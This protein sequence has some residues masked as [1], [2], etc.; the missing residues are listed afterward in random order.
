LRRRITAVRVVGATLVLLLALVVCGNSW[1]TPVT[2]IKP[3]V[4]FSPGEM[5]SRYLSA[6]T[7]SPYLGFPNFN[8]GLGPV[9]AALAP[10]EVLG[11]SPEWLFKV[12][13]LALW[14]VAALGARSALQ[15]LAPS[16]GSW[17]G[18]T[19]AALYVAN[20]YAVVGGSTLAILLPY[21]FLPWLVV[22]LVHALRD[23]RSW[24]GPAAFGLAFF[25]MSGMNV[26]V[27]PI[28]QLL[29]VPP[30]AGVVGRALG[31]SWRTV[32]VVLA[33]CALVLVAVSLYWL[34]PA[35]SATSTGLQVTAES[36]RI[37]GIAHVSSMVEVLRGMGMWSIY[38]HGSG[39][40]W[41]PEFAPYLAHP[42]LVLVTCAWPILGLLGLVGAPPVL[43]RV[44]AW[45][46]GL[47]TVVLVGFFP[48]GA[49]TPL[50]WGV[51]RAFELVP[52]LVAFR[53]TNKAGAVLA[54]AFALLLGHALPRWLGALRN[55]RSPAVATTGG[56]AVLPLV[57]AWVLPA[58]TGNLYTSPFDPPTYWTAAARSVDRQAHDSRVLFLPSQIRASY[59]WSDE[60]PDDLSNS[61]MR[62]EAIVPESS[63]NASAPGA[64]VLAALGDLVAT[65]AASTT[66][67]STLAR[68]LGA[69]DVLLRHDTR[70]EDANG[71]RPAASAG[72]LAADPGLLGVAN[73]GTPGENVVGPAGP[74]LFEPT[75]PPV[76]HYAVKAATST[77]SARSLTDSITVAGDGWAFDSLARTGRVTST[78][79]V[80][81][82]HDLDSRDLARQLGPSHRLVISD[83]NRRRA[84][85]PNRLTAGQGPL[86]AEDSADPSPTRVLGG[87]DDQTVLR[88]RGPTV[89]ASQVGSAFFDTPYGQPDNVLDGDDS[90]SWLFGDFDRAPGSTLKVRW[91][92]PQTL[93]RV[94]IRPTALGAVHLDSVTLTAGH[95]AR[96]VQ[97]PDTGTAVVDLG[98]VVTDQLTL[99]VNATR[100]EGFSLVG[101]AELGLPGEKVERVAR[102]PV[103]LN[104]LY[105]GLDPE[106]REKFERTPMDVSFTRVANGSN[107]GDDSETQLLR[108]FSLPVSRRFSSVASV[109]MLERTEA[110]FDRLY[111]GTKG[112]VASSSGTYFDNPDLRASMASDGDPGTAWIPGGDGEGAWWQIDGVRRP[113]KSV[114]VEQRRS[115]PG[116]PARTASRVRVEV[117]GDVV[118]LAT[119][120]AGSTE[121]ELPSGTVGS[122]VRLVILD[123]EGHA[124]ALPPQFVTID[125]GAITSTRYRMAC[126]T[127]AE[128]DGQ[129]FRM[130]PVDLGAVSR[131]G[132]GPTTWVGCKPLRLGP[133]GHQV[134]ARKG[135]VLDKLDLVDRRE[136]RSTTDAGVDLVSDVEGRDVDQLVTV[137]A[138]DAPVALKMGQSWDPRWRASL[139]GEDLGPPVQVDGWSTGWVLPAGGTRTV[140]V[141]FAPQRTAAVG[142][143]VSALT[144]VGAAGLCLWGFRRRPSASSR[145]VAAHEREVDLVPR[146]GTPSWA[147]DALCAGA[148]G[149]TFGLP[150]LAGMAAALALARVLALPAGTRVRVGAGLVGLA[151]AL[152]VM[153]SRG[154]WG[155][156]DAGVPSAT[157]WPHWVAIVGVVVALVSTIVPPPLAARRWR[158][159]RRAGQHRGQSPPPASASSAVDG[160]A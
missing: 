153:T 109:R 5:F 21:A 149:L 157:M 11:L 10:G 60:R 152:Q 70:W 4:Y 156:V 68:Y 151:G 117:D 120:R 155:T 32:L 45:T 160:T 6:W 53:T 37:D 93:G 71:A 86:L 150:G 91:T 9:V 111:G 143:A 8:V 63:P 58:V 108:D 74:I 104:T 48:G 83:T 56:V 65:N 25:A 66:T 141:E 103:V 2:D 134:R 35:L 94:S 34:I 126:T 67:V 81:F 130:R 107:P 112:V 38:G 16:T 118:A 147:V 23:P 122:R 92:T 82:A 80:W 72:L 119:L 114:L 139:D 28:F 52:P 84:A 77:V 138:S 95:T 1:G 85:I 26:A 13:H 59:R 30:V 31:H 131:S 40:A 46:I 145:D 132:G 29:V 124:D 144:V 142:L 43:R 110:A 76:Q 42:L 17:A 20:P 51:E 129:P 90:T 41:V 50:A 54:L 102:T 19:A 127:V 125:T 158:P 3:E 115:S 88:R 136:G 18:L 62:R 140:H 61:L 22:A 89:T 57:V 159:A 154:S 36:E 49:S 101:I 99:R 69:G 39:G 44:S 78:P 33:R 7:G 116:A 135:W 148:T 98:G 27:V 79:V 75:L 87:P 100:G 14:L 47:A 123:V 137:R 24:R 97:L 73:F 106:E 96:E 64:N 55:S 128:I 121:I 146:P 105:A 15:A 12:F 133:G 113:L